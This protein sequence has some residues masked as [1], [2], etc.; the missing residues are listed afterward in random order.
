MLTVY[1]VVRNRIAQAAV[2]SAEPIS[3]RRAEKC[4]AFLRKNQ[5]AASASI[6]LRARKFFKTRAAA[7]FPP[8]RG[9]R[10]ILSAPKNSASN[11][12]FEFVA[13]SGLRGN[14]KT[15]RVLARKFFG[16]VS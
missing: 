6:V 5:N 16:N 2:F 13:A 9:N 12:S 11:F 14:I 4:N 8:S 1:L 15:T 7:K 10:K 3:T